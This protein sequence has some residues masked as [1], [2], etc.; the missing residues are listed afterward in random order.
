LPA[1][2]R[3]LLVKIVPK[4]TH[5]RDAVGTDRCD[6]VIARNVAMGGELGWLRARSGR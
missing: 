6:P 2:W 4:I 1:Y 3:S 5:L